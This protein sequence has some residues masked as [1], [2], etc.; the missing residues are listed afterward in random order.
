MNNNKC[1]VSVLIPCRNEELYIESVIDS[2]INQ[3]FDQINIEIIIIDGESIDGTQGLVIEY[4]KKHSNIT[5]LNNE[6]HTVPFALNLGI[7][8]A[9]GDIIV[10][11]DAHAEYPRNYISTLVDNLFI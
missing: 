4:C 10:R 9:K 1:F 2:I 3:T 6:H 8:E 11:M 5:L 7:Q